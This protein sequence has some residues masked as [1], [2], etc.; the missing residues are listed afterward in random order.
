[1]ETTLAVVMT[2][3]LGVMVGVEASVAFVVNPI[4]LALPV[5]STVAARAHGARMLGRL[6]PFWYFA[7][8]ALVVALAAVRWGQ[9]AATAA[10]AAAA[11]LAVS[12]VMSVLWLVPINNR[13]ASWTPESHPADWR[14]QQRR[15]DRLHCVRVGVIVAA[16][17]CAA[18]AAA[19]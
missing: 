19:L 13:S 9:P 6:M 11:L 7:S 18:L 15:W 2:T 3:V 10:L 5:S 1:M 14:E 4:T 8:L 16:L 12:V 17:V